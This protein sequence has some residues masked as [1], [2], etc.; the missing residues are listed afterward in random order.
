MCKL[1][2]EGRDTIQPTFSVRGGLPPGISG[3]TGEPASDEEGF[4]AMTPTV[5]TEVREFRT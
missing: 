4:R 2:V 3:A 5:G 1:V